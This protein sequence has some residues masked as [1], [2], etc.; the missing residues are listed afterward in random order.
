MCQTQNGED[1]NKKCQFPFVFKNITHHKCTLH[2]ESSQWC[3]TEKSTSYHEDRKFGSCSPEP[4]C[5]FETGN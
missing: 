5:E 1:P 3:A 2:G 4:V